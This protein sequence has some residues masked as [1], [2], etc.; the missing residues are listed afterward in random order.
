MGISEAL[1]FNVITRFSL[2]EVPL[3]LLVKDTEMFNKF[4]R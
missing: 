3:V 4:F 1:F 2:D